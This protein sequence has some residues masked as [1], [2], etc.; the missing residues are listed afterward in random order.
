MR[1]RLGRVRIPLSALPCL[2]DSKRL[3]CDM[4]MTKY[5]EG[6]QYDSVGETRGGKSWYLRGERPVRR[7][8]ARRDA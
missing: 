6:T 4:S 2:M 8:R 5:R 1:D 7:S 3:P